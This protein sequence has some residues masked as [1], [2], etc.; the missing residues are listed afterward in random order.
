MIENSPHPPIH[1]SEC[2]EGIE[3]PQQERSQRALRALLQ[4]A[5][6]LFTR[7]GFETTIAGI[8]EEAG[9]TVAS[10]YRRFADKNAVFRAVVDLWSGSLIADSDRMWAS[11]DWSERTARDMLQFHIDLIFSAYAAGP[12]LLLEIDGRSSKMVPFAADRMIAF[13]RKSGKSVTVKTS[14]PPPAPD[15]RHR[16]ARHR[17]SKGGL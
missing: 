5:A 2:S 6:K 16:L 1:W 7:D 8:V 12:G 14:I 15:E 13:I 3:A 11:V 17:R 9:V 10:L 4:A